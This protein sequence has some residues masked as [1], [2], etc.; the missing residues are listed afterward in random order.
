MALK[1]PINGC[2]FTTRRYPRSAG[3]RERRD[4]FKNAHPEQWNVYVK[5]KQQERKERSF[6]DRVING[7]NV[8]FNDVIQHPE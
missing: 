5:L 7:S 4:H 8:S 6:F 2:G 3:I 1:C